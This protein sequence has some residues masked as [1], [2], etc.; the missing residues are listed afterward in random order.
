MGQG[1]D[2][3]ISGRARSITV[4]RGLVAVMVMFHHAAPLLPLVDPHYVEPAFG[5]FF[6]FSS[7]RI[8]FFLVASGFLIGQRHIGDIG[9][10]D[11]LPGFVTRRLLGIAP[12]YWL[13]LGGLLMLGM[14]SIGYHHVA[15]PSLATIVSSIL[16][17]GP[18][19]HDTVLAV[20]WTLY[21]EMLFYAVFAC[22]LIN[23]RLGLW[24]AAGWAL[25]IFG[26]VAGI[27]VGGLPAYVTDPIN[28]LFFIGFGAA[29]GFRQARGMPAGWL[30]ALAVVIAAG[31]LSDTTRSAEPDFSRQWLW[32]VAW[33]AA[34]AAL[35]TWEARRAFAAPRAFCR[36]G[37]AAFALYL[38]HLPL[39]TQMAHLGRWLR[40]NWAGTI[41]AEPVLLLMGSSV[42]GAALA[43][44]HWI[45][46]PMQSW[47][48]TR[49]RGRDLSGWLPS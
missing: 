10:P 11:R 5:G 16:L 43:V 39:L 17:I 33:A 49:R 19:S 38:I 28:L 34:I 3:A 1:V 37:E 24:V 22:A 8:E 42:I 46:R 14:T 41:A 13:V 44:H 9:H 30:A 48:R 31:L 18:D 2:E 35:M 20:A 7:G 29:V 47:L 4:V 45:E 21:H 36:L 32:G 26:Q 40:G 12:L 15:Y 6:G 27:T 25:L 23:R